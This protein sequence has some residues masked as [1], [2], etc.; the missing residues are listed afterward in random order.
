MKID[1]ITLFPEMFKCI[2]LYGVI[3]RAHKRGIWTLNIWNPRDFSNKICQSVDDRAY[4]GGSSMIML[5]FP[6]EKTVNLINDIRSKEGL[7]FGPNILLTP[8]GK[9]FDQKK[10]RI[11]TKEC[12]IILVCGRYKG[13]D[14]RFIDRCITDEIS[15]GDFILSGG[16]IAALAII[17]SIVRLLPGVINQNS[18]SQD[19]F[20]DDVSGLLDSPHYTRPKKYKGHSVPSVLLSGNHAKILEWRRRQSLIVTALRRPELIFRARENGLINEWDEKILQEIN[21]SLQKINK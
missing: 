7:K 9:Q 6:L 16:E 1:V 2:R 10:A 19:S 20:H 15:L 8:T 17:D 5:A 4:G 12:R 18:I 11:L 3:G 14:Q 13:I 21:F